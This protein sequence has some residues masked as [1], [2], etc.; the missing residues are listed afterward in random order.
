MPSPNL[1]GFVEVDKDFGP[2][3]HPESYEPARKCIKKAQTAPT[4]QQ[5]LKR[6]LSV[7]A[8][9]TDKLEHDQSMLYT[10]CRLR[11]GTQVSTAFAVRREK[12]LSASTANFE[13]LSL[14][15]RAILN[16]EIIPVFSTLQQGMVTLYGTVTTATA[17]TLRFFL[18]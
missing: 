14:G 18:G 10:R 9:C 3:V 17:I 11:S 5:R 2:V 12:L 15:C 13:S 4:K 7:L 6:V 1:V 16:G 8:K